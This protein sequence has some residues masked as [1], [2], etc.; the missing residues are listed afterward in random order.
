MSEVESELIAH[1][2]TVSITN[3]CR[4]LSKS[5]SAAFIDVGKSSRKILILDLD[6]TLVHSSFRKTDNWDFTVTVEYQ[7]STYDI[8]VQKRPGVDSF[9]SQLL[10]NFV[11]FIFTASMAEYSIPIVKQLLPDFPLSNILSR[12]HCRFFQGSFVKDLSI[13]NCKLSDII[14][15]DNSSY[16]YCLQ[17]QNGIPVKTW[18]GD[19]TDS[20]LLALTLPLLLKCRDHEDVRHIISSKIC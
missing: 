8:Y 12:Q 14:I 10:Q 15:V 13:F 11:V 7:G 1:T 18:T 5:H 20:E 3:A 2:P 9:L 16:S 19:S 6:E 17:P 4:S